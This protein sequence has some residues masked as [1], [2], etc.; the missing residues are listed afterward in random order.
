MSK[1]YYII[2][3]VAIEA[4]PDEIRRAYRKKALELHPDHYGQDSAPF[5]DVQEAYGVLSDPARRQDYDRARERERQAVAGKRAHSAHVRPRRSRPEPLI[6]ERSRYVEDISLTRSFDTFR[7]SFEEIFDRLWSNFTGAAQPKSSRAERLII[8][9]PVPWE[10]AM[11][12]GHVRVFVPAV[13]TCPVCLGRGGMGPFE[14]WQCGGVGALAGEFPVDVAFPA[15]M[16]DDY[17]VSVAL[18]SLG[19]ANVYLAVRFRVT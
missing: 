11:E 15:G 9:V 2:L 1:D 19:I 6:P 18:D 5:L 13:D 8:E 16:P 14:C 4:S 10:Q 12:G 3:G 7:P 17:V